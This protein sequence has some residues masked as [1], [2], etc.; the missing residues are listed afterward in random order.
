M[1]VPVQHHDHHLAHHQ[2]FAILT[3]STNQKTLPEAQRTQKLTPQMAPLALVAN[4]GHQMELF[5]LIANLATR[6]RHLRQLHQ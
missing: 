4:F 3:L 5:A 2:E 6:R 1:S